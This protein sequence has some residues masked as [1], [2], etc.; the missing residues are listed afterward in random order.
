[1]GCK[2]L[3][4]KTKKEID[5]LD[6][7]VEGFE[8][9]KRKTRLI[10][11]YDAFAM[12][13]KMIFMYGMDQLVIKLT[14]NGLKGLSTKLKAI[15]TS[16]AATEWSN[17]GG[18]LIPTKSVQSMLQQIKSDKLNSWDEVHQFYQTQTDKYLAKKN[19]HALYC[20]EMIEGTS[21]SGLSSKKM[22]EWLDRYQ[23]IKEE[24]T[25]KIKSS[26][27]KDYTNPFRKMVYE[28]QAEMDAIVGDLNDNSFIIEQIEAQ[29][30]FNQF[31]L[32]LKQALKAK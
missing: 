14:Q 13:E 25:Q 2:L 19:L 7:F 5:Q 28:N 27:E 22:N 29:K 3:T 16:G 15:K 17:I 6:V 20:L 8:N 11:C 12:F 4:T 18:Q 26:R 32:E 21:I 24:I 1:L 30:Q 31:I 10:K 9:S 23:A